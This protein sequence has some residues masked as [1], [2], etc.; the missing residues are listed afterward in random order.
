MLS[1]R[2]IVMDADVE[3][4]QSRDYKMAKETVKLHTASDR[5]IDKSPQTL[6]P[7][8]DDNSK[9]VPIERRRSNRVTKPASHNAAR[10][11]VGF[12]IR[13]QVGS[14]NQPSTSDSPQHS[15]PSVSEPRPDMPI[16]YTPVTGRISRAKKGVPVHICDRDHC[17]KA[18]FLYGRSRSSC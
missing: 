11:A 12:Y 16:K 4:F 15:S 7:I 6:S 14:S 1:L 9:E 8:L 17:R 10:E 18:S 2:D 5:S 3:P 13:F